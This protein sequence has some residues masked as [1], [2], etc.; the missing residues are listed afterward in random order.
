MDKIGVLWDN[1]VSWE[2]GKPFE[3]DYVNQT[4]RLFSQ[5]AAEEDIR[6]VIGK[7][8]WYDEGGIEKAY[9]LE[10]GE[11]TKKE[12]VNLN[13]VFDKFH[14]DEETKELKKNVNSRIGILN[15]PELEEICKD[16]LLT[17]KK[18][19]DRIPETKKASE[20][21][22]KQML[23]K[24]GKTVLKPRYAFGGKGIHVLESFDEAPNVDKEAYIVQ[25]FIDS[26][27]GIEG[28]VEGFHD[29]RAIMVDGE[30]KGSYLRFNEG[31]AVSNV[32]QGGKKEAV[33]KQEFPEE[34]LK[35]AQEVSDELE[36]SPSLFSVDFFYDAEGS[37]W[38]VELNS[39]PGLNFYG[40]EELRRQVEPVMKGLVQAFKQIADN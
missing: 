15:S 27:K 22:I 11:W 8:T 5:L 26:S 7:Y 12:N 21:N 17:Y 3:E 39:K 25:R 32:A 37:P 20:Q 6:L 31:R 13:G 30:M 36:Y 35:I 19:P 4:Y 34:A 24:H 40:E 33:E 9:I 14:F 28:L 38:I 10:N 16:K 18:F 29:L 2:G 23:E 1:E